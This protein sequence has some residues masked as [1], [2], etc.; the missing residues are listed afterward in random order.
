[1]AWRSS[2]MP[3]PG[4][5]WLPRPSSTAFAAARATDSGPSTSG[6]PWPRLTEP[7]RTARADISAKIVVPMPVRRWLSRGLRTGAAYS[8]GMR[9][10]LC[11]LPLSPQPAVNLDRVRPALAEAAAQHADLAVFPEATQLRF[12]C[13]PRPAA[14]GGGEGV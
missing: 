5:Y 10:A 13:D 3:G 2:G 6:K 14:G 11:Q 9:V 7:V 12:G 8:G 4:G 1:M